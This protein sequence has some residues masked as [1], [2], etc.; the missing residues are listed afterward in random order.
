MFSILIVNIVPPLW[1]E[2]I[3]NDSLT[4]VLTNKEM[5]I[6]GAAIAVLSALI[7]VFY[8]LLQK[9]LLKRLSSTNILLFIYSLAI[10]ILAPFSDIGAFFTL[11]GYDWLIL[12]FCALNTVIAY[13]AF[14]QSMKHIDPT[15]VSMLISTIPL[16]TIALSYLTF[17]I[18]PMYFTFDEID[19]IGWLGIFMVVASVIIF[20]KA[21]Q[22]KKK[23]KVTT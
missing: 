23:C 18:W 8:A 16:F 1:V 22:A 15:Q 14:A 7:W 6:T 21:G 2:V 3:F 10:I 11:D 20:N 12:L 4:A 19:L 5:L 17:I 13:G 9:S